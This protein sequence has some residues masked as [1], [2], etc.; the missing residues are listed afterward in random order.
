MNL[1]VCILYN[2]NCFNPKSVER[3]LSPHLLSL[4]P[5]FLVYENV[6]MHK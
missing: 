3:F 4:R 2:M 1:N 6:Y 5:V